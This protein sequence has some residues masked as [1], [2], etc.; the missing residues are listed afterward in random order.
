MHNESM[1]RMFLQSII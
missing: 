1:R